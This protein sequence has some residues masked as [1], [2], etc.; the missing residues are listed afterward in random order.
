MI[1]CLDCGFC[2]TKL[3]E[4]TAG[5]ESVQSAQSDK[6]DREI[7]EVENGSDEM[8]NDCNGTNSSG[9]S[10]HDNRACNEEATSGSSSNDKDVEKE[11]KQ[12]K[13]PILELLS[14]T[15]HSRLSGPNTQPCTPP[16]SKKI[17]GQNAEN[18]FN[19]TSSKYALHVAV[20]FS[21]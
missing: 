18:K 5:D 4:H 3:E 21:D 6:C 7:R 8:K 16:G 20:G 9:E 1:K 10:E 19:P 2:S 12:E 11:E 17:R 15:G 13:N 14:K